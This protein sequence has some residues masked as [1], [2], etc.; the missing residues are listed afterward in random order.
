MQ[1]ES[2]PSGL[3]NEGGLF[4][5]IDIE[6]LIQ[7]DISGRKTPQQRESAL[8]R[9]YSNPNHCLCC[10]EII[11][12][13]KNTSASKIRRKK[14]CDEVCA[15]RYYRDWRKCSI[16]GRKI[17]KS[18]QTGL[19]AICAK[20]ERD[21]KR[22]ELWRETGDTGRNALTRVPECIKEYIYAKQ[23]NKCAICGIDAVWNRR[24]LHFILDH[25][26]GNASDN[27]EQ[28]LRLICPNC[29]S[30]LDTYKSRNKN[31]ARSSRR[32]G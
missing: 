24:E 6:K 29:D 13:D 8:R 10:G 28:N 31:S 27:R 18:N 3:R 23:N 9:Y 16:C 19:C 26:D 1:T 25:I 32:T 30:Q 15:G 2:C 7:D 4:I 20:D 14:F 22:L 17:S 5:E 21:R 12:V 11:L